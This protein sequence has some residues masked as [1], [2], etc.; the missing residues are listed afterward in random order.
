MLALHISN[1]YL[2]LRPV[3]E[4]AARDVGK[5]A[6]LVNNDDDHRE[7]IYAA[8]WILHR[9]VRK[10]STASTRWK[11]RAPFFYPW[12]NERPWTD[13]YSSVLKILKWSRAGAA[14]GLFALRE[15]CASAIPS[16]LEAAR[17]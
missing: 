2:N 4:A 9:E 8:S 15:Q 13:D 6:I 16:L 12:P 11:Q 14:H 1:Q 5:E 17:L 3:V 7:G 10:D